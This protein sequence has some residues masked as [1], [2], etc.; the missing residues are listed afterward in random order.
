MIAALEKIAGENNVLAHGKEK[1][2]FYPY[3]ENRSPA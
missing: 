1:S 3:L 2:P